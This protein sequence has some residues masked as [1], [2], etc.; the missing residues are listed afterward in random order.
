[1]SDLHRAVMDEIDAHAPA[2][3]PPF[4]TIR[5]RKRRRDRRNLGVAGAGLAV[6]GA[7][8]LLVAVPALGDRGTS[9]NLVAGK[10]PTAPPSAAPSAS[11]CSEIQAALAGITR[12][13][14][15][16]WPPL[17]REGLALVTDA[18]H[19]LRDAQPHLP[20]PEQELVWQ[21][22]DALNQIMLGDADPP[23]F[24]LLASIRRDLAAGCP[25]YT[26]SSSHSSP[27][28]DPLGIHA[29]PELNAPYLACAR[30]KGFDP[31]V[32]EVFVNHSDKPMFVKTGNEVPAAVHRPCWVRLGGDDPFSTSYGN[33][34]RD[35]PVVEG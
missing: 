10:D 8:T 4:S 17:S 29:A 28:P 7:V 33:G 23:P 25:E 20:Q 34:S 15:G 35:D 26:H 12:A 13:T 16:A 9:E 30:E 19:V 27:G 31:Q 18:N 32:A 6:A 3:A 2:A 14:V 5:A 21:A 22:R 11:P 24:E 1:M